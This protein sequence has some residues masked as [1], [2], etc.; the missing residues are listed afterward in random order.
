MNQ[1]LSG[2]R[3]TGHCHQF[4]RIPQKELSIEKYFSQHLRK[5]SS[6]NIV[7][8][9]LSTLSFTLDVLYSKE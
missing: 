5:Y 9:N 3:C 6:Q 2:D 1:T 4:W 8:L 7:L